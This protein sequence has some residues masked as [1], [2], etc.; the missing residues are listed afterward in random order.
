MPRRTLYS[1]T[2]VSDTIF[3]CALYFISEREECV[4]PSEKVLFWPPP[5]GTL[6]LSPPPPDYHPMH[7]LRLDLVLGTKRWVCPGS[8]PAC[9]E[10]E[11]V[12]P[13]VPGSVTFK[14]ITHPTCSDPTRGYP[15]Q[16]LGSL[17]ETCVMTKPSKSRAEWP[18]FL[19]FFKTIILC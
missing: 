12:L 18:T 4:K 14:Y 11:G 10:S 1:P 13:R 2:P 8:R 15:G 17:S 3:S 5:L 19:G 16:E 7:R 6:S 9:V